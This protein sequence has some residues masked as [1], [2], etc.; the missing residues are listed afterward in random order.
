MKHEDLG[1][2]KFYYADLFGTFKIYL[3]KFSFKDSKFKFILIHFL[4]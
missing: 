2:D 1:Q 4:I 3:D